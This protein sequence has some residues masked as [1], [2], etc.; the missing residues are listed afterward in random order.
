MKRLLLMI[1][2]HIVLLGVIVSV[3]LV[4][5]FSIITFVPSSPRLIPSLLTGIIPVVVFL[6]PAIITRAINRK[7]VR[8]EASAYFGVNTLVAA[9]FGIVCGLLIFGLLPRDKASSYKNAEQTGTG[10]PAT[11]PVVEPEGGDKPQ[12]EAEGRSR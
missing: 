5:L 2:L 4:G 10:Q 11:R 9:L 3:L 12:P 6:E 8:R 7:G 1:D